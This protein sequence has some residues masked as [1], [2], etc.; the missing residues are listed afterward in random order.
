M[1]SIYTLGLI[2]GL[3]V[4]DTTLGTTVGNLGWEETRFPRPVFS[5]DTAARGNGGRRGPPQRRSRP[6]PGNRHLRAS[7]VQSARRR[8]G[9]L[10]P[11]GADDEQAGMRLR[12]LLFV[13]GDSERKFAKASAC[14]ADGLILDLEDAVA[15]PR[16]RRTRAN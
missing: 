1:N 3:S 14:G 10:S 13:P 15:H 9:L 16:K 2:V 4:Y 6:T 5:G 11:G 8:S 7:R 12:S